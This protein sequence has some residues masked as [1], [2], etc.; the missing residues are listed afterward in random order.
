MNKINQSAVSE[1][2]FLFQFLSAQAQ[3]D[4]DKAD[5]NPFVRI[6]MPDKVIPFIVTADGGVIADIN[7]N[8]PKTIYENLKS[9]IPAATLQGG[10]G[11]I[12][13]FHGNKLLVFKHVESGI[14]GKEW[15]VDDVASALQF[16]LGLYY[17]GYQIRSR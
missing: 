15:L 17:P 4:L 2:E 12:E 3:A 7:A 8:N 1:S 5:A 16:E 11:F 9:V 6:S 10:A 14:F 13:V